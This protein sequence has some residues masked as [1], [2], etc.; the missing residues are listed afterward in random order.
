[1]L[2]LKFGTLEIPLLAALDIDQTYPPIGGEA[3]LRTV[4]GAG[5]KQMTWRKTRI[6]T[7]GGGWL[8][9]GL[10]TLDTSASIAIACV[11]PRRVPAVF[12]TRQATLPAARRADS[13]HLPWGVAILPD[14][15]AVKTP[16]TLAGNVATLDAVANAVSYH[17]LYLPLITCWLMRPTDSGTPGD[18]NYRWEITAEEA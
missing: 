16:A 4:S 3:L 17:A 1:M 18:A 15:S 5:I 9:A 12:A 2:I 11:V 7:N 8:P 10:D 6:V 14:N 13:G